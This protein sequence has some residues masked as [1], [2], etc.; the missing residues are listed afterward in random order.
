MATAYTIRY[1][2]EKAGLGP[3]VETPVSVAVGFDGVEVGSATAAGVG[4][5]SITDKAGDVIERGSGRYGIESSADEVSMVMCL[6][7]GGDWRM[8]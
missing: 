6:V 3:G 2:R 4:G 5:G 1:G 8:V 7:G